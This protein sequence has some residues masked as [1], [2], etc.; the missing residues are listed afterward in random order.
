MR[1]G[2]WPEVTRFWHGPAE[3]SPTTTVQAPQSPSAQPSFVPRRHATS[4]RYSSTVIV[5]GGRSIA[6]TSPSRTKRKT[7]EEL[8][9]ST[10]GRVAPGRDQQRHMVVLPCIRNAK[11]DDDLIEKRRLGEFHPERAEVG[12]DVKCQRVASSAE[13]VAFEQGRGAAAVSIGSRNGGRRR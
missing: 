4:R 7:C 13:R 10:V 12:G 5:A 2:L 6:T 3:S 9:T 11:R 8:S 1:F